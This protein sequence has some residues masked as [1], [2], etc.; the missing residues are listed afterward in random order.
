MKIASITPPQV[1]TRGAYQATSRDLPSQSFIVYQSI[2]FIA[3]SGVNYNE[4]FAD[5]AAL[6][7]DDEYKLVKGCA[8]VEIEIGMTDQATFT[9]SEKQSATG[10][11]GQIFLDSKVTL[12]TSDADCV[13]A[14]VLAE[15]NPANM[16]LE[17]I[18]ILPFAPLLDDKEYRLIE[19]HREVD[20]EDLIANTA[21]SQARRAR[22][23]ARKGAAP[24]GRLNEAPQNRSIDT[25]PNYVLASL[26][27]IQSTSSFKN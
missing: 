21:N 16:M 17:N 19:I 6:C 20:V 18:F 5:G 27:D 1:N 24:S 4:P 15:V 10:R 14:L 12:M 9:I 22:N 2:E 23:A 11:K 26:R 7:L 25:V 3:V 8:P 13:E